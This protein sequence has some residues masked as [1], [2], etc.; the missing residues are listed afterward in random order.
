MRKRLAIL[1]LVFMMTAVLLP[2]IAKA[3][4]TPPQLSTV[5]DVTLTD[6]AT[7]WISTEADLA[8]LAWLVRHGDADGEGEDCAGNYF[9]LTENITLTGDYDAATAG[10]W[11]PI[12]PEGM[13]D[14]TTS[15]YI[16]GYQFNGTFYGQNHTISGLN[17]QTPNN[18]AG[19]FGLIG[20]GG[21]VLD[22][23]VEGTFAGTGCPFG[24]IV[25]VGGIAGMNC[26]KIYNCTNRATYTNSP[27]TSYNYIGGIVGLNLGIV[28]NC[29]NNAAITG[30]KIDYVG[31]DNFVG[32]IAGYC[33]RNATVL[34]CVNTAPIRGESNIG[35]IAGSLAAGSPAA[36]IQNCYNTGDITATSG[37]GGI[38]GMLNSYSQIGNC[39]S[40]GVI[41]V[42]PGPGGAVVGGIESS[43]IADNCFW[44]TAAASGYGYIFTPPPFGYDPVVTDFVRF[45]GTD[46]LSSDVG[47]T[48]SLCTALNDYVAASSSGN[49]LS[50]TGVS[51][52][53]VFTGAII[54]S[55]PDN[56]TTFTGR[57]ARFSVVA[58]GPALTYQWEVSTDGGDWANVSTGS[59]GNTPIYTTDAVTT[60]MNGNRYRCAVSGSTDPSGYATLTVD[61]APVITTQPEDCYVKIGD[62]P[63]FSVV[64]TGSPIPT[65]QWFI[66][67]T[68][69][70]VWHPVSS[71]GSPP[72]AFTLYLD[73]MTAGADGSSYKCELE[74]AYGTV[75]SDI[76]TLHL[77][78]APV[79][80]R[81]PSDKTAA[82]GKTATFSVA[83]TGMAPLSYQWQVDRGSGW[84]II[85]DATEDS[86]TTAPVT[87][88]NNGYRYRVVVMNRMEMDVTSDPATLHVVAEAVIPTTGDA[89]RPGLWIGAGLLA[90]ACLAGAVRFLW[91]RRGTRL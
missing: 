46:A 43:V 71:T 40:T 10:N 81:Q 57:T 83:A 1:L 3:D 61:S 89:A 76:A 24:G 72:D 22:L 52:L 27:S 35:G 74:N 77:A 12:G 58:I 48:S 60:G 91:K 85:D 49:L 34:N 54:L 73:P 90:A 4:A 64:A 29:V 13:Y 55:D 79:I 67:L 28:Q 84:D 59:G 51:S 68:G 32:G 56:S 21:T 30:R 37:G 9:V 44:N 80:T 69:D 62:T 23:T 45:T 86:Y 47:G 26:G 33:H 25:G 18:S 50:W 78:T 15:P 41:A 17:V 8:R 31:G 42:G 20:S 6:G 14:V 70:P 39:Y 36:T 75:T 38:V 65:C 19:L 82:V 7:Y 87:L 2:K 5:A 16:F 66:L 53:P 11:T 88:L 63:V